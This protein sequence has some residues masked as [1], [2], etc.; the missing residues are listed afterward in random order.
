[1]IRLFPEE[2]EG[3]N[4]KDKKIEGRKKVVKLNKD[5][6]AAEEEVEVVGYMECCKALCVR[7]SKKKICRIMRTT[8]TDIYPEQTGPQTMSG[9]GECTTK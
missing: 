7:V 9:V 4:E 2:P 8:S 3:N 6:V 5:M 1:L